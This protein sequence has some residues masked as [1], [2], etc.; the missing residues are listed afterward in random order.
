MMETT[1]LV[2][3]IL[4]VVAGSTGAVLGVINTW[5]NIKRDR[6]RLRVRATWAMT[7]LPV[8]GVEMV[9]QLEVVN[10]SE[11]PVTIADVGFNMS[12]GGIASLS[13]VPGLLNG[14][15]LPQRLDPR[16]RYF[17]VFSPD[18]I[19]GIAVE[20][21]SSYARTECGVTARGKIVGLK[22]LLANRPAGP[23]ETS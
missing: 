12:G 8:Q 20:M 3:A 11:F 9:A 17:K 5:M 4:G 10:L 21:R 7:A 23:E 6:V 15:S 13:T 19:S 22:S 1:T 2:V 18:A 14:A 16:S